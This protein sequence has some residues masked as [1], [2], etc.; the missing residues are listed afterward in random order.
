MTDPVAD[1]HCESGRSTQLHHEQ[2]NRIL[3]APD[4]HPVTNMR[5]CQNHLK[6][7]QLTF[8][9]FMAFYCSHDNDLASAFAPGDANTAA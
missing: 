3:S 4:Y 5:L 1:V 2:H 6:S 9:S 7:L 8:A